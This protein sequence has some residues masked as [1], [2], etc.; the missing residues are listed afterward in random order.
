[1]GQAL[2]PVVV[3][4]ADDAEAGNNPIDRNCRETGL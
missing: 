3:D 1:M 2:V 4:S